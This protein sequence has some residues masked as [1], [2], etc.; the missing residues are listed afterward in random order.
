MS[1]N[2]VRHERTV[3]F[4]RALA[5]AATLAAAPGQAAEKTDGRLQAQMRRLQQQ[6]RMTE[7]EKAQLVQQKSDAENQLKN[8][9]GGVTEAQRHAGALAA[10]IAVLNNELK[11]AKAKHEAVNA[12][13]AALAESSKAEYA[14]LAAKLAEAERRLSEQR[15]AFDAEKRRLESALATSASSTAGCQMRNDRLH[16]LGNELLERYEKK[17]CVA[18]LLQAEPVTGL[19]RAQVEKVVEEYREKLDKEQLLPGQKGEGAAPAQ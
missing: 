14:A 17:S 13:K 1:G 9:Q 4:V 12:E 15:I 8:A 11:A 7:Q 6:L 3:H 2:P 5:L 19:K 16:R 18:S 10:R